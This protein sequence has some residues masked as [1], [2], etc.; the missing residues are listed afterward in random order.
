MARTDSRPVTPHLQPREVR[1]APT[2]PPWLTV[3]MSR[4]I[5]PP[6]PPATSSMDRFAEA[7]LAVSVTTVVSLA[8]LVGGACVV[9]WL[10]VRNSRPED[11]SAVLRA[12]A[13]VL[14]AFASVVTRRRQR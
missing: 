9:V 6:Q 7:V 3:V 2:R 8:V 10:A 5:T 11:R 14:I 1:A 13:H 12:L 4:T